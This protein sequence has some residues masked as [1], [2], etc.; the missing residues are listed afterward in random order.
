MAAY[1]EQNDRH[2]QILMQVV[3]RHLNGANCT[4]EMSLTRFMELYFV[5]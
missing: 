4:H 3:L 5:T 1:E 2:V